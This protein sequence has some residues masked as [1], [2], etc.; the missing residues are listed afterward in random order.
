MWL[1]VRV[2]SSGCQEERE[3]ERE[4]ESCQK[5]SGSGLLIGVVEVGNQ[6][7]GCW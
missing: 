3:R 1:L 6:E 2:L 5:V 4:R 7:C